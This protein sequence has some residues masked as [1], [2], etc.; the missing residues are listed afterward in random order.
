MCLRGTSSRYSFTWHSLYLWRRLNWPMNLRKYPL[1][2]LL[3]K[4]MECRLDPPLESDFRLSIQVEMRPFVWGTHRIVW[5]SWL[6]PWLW[7]N[8]WSV[9][10]NWLSGLVERTCYKTRAPAYTCVCV[11]ACGVG[12][13]WWC[14]L[15]R[16]FFFFNI[17]VLLTRMFHA[18]LDCFTLLKLGVAGFVLSECFLL[19]MFINISYTKKGFVNNSTKLLVLTGTQRTDRLYMFCILCT[20]KTGSCDFTETGIPK[21]CRHWLHWK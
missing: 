6:M 13:G 4:V 12:M 10:R 14:W 21:Y 8:E 18:W 16:G 7:L 1:I 2:I 9:G 11:C 19:S 17:W 5:M 3:R 15:H 20:L